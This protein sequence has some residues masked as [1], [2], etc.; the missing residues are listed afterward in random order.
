MY[1][2]N[3]KLVMLQNTMKFKLLRT[4]SIF[5]LLHYLIHTVSCLGNLSPLQ[6]ILCAK[7]YIHIKNFF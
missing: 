5:F 7:L 2:K 1:I 3:Q 4:L 6:L